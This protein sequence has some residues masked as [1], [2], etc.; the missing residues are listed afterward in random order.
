MRGRGQKGN[1]GRVG[2]VYA[3]MGDAAEYGE[4]WAMLGQ[5]FEVRGELIRGSGSGGEEAL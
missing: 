2:T 1:I 3:R 5:K 4:F